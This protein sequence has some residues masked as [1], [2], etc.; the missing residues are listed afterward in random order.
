MNDKRCWGITK[1]F[2]R[3]KNLKTRFLVCGYHL[4]QPLAVGISVLLFVIA[5]F[6]DVL[7]IAAYFALGNIE[8]IY[9]KNTADLDNVLKY[10]Q[11]ALVIDKEIGYKK[12][13]A[14]DLGNIGNV[15]Y[16][17]GDQDNALRY[18]FKALVIDREIG[19]K[20]GEA[21]QLGNIGLI[22]SDKGELDNALKYLQKAKVIFKKT[23]ARPQSIIA[24]RA[25]DIL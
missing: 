4:W 23:D 5:F 18:H 13:E 1:K 17:K 2:D 24:Q 8:V 3:C 16:A 9:N 6:S 14:L 11:E 15:Y 12:G 21:S 7:G 25:I 10:L 19:Y 20:Q 22:Y